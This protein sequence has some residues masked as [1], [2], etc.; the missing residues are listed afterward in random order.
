MVYNVFLKQ[1]SRWEPSG[2]ILPWSDS[3]ALCPATPSVFQPLPLSGGKWCE[4]SS[5]VEQHGRHSKTKASKDLPPLRQ[6]CGMSAP[7]L[8]DEKKYTF[9]YLTTG[10]SLVSSSRCVHDTLEKRHRYAT[11]EIGPSSLCACARRSQIDCSE[12]NIA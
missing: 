11:S 2:C 6:S 9:R 8:L 12:I 10:S 1:Y 5:T 4:V 7:V 3:A